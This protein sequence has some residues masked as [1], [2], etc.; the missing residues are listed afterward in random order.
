MIYDLR[1]HRISFH[2]TKS[3]NVCCLMDN[4]MDGEK[5]DVDTNILEQ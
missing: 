5:K 4:A 3:L 2:P 1:R